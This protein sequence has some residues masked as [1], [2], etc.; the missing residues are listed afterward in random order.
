MTDLRESLVQTDET[1]RQLRRRV[2]SVRADRVGEELETTLELKVAVDVLDEV[3]RL[4]QAGVAQLRHSG[5]PAE[6]LADLELQVAAH[7]GRLAQNEIRRRLRAR[8]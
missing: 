6:E 7:R 5:R 4:A 1:L 3:V 8:H 2:D